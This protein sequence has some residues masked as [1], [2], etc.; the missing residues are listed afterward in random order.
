MFGHENGYIYRYN[1]AR[2]YI[3]EKTLY[4]NE[5]NQT[6]VYCARD[7]KI[8]RTVVLK[9]IAVRTQKEKRIVENEVKNMILA[10]EKTEFTP[11]VY[12]Y[13]WYSENGTYIVIMQ[14]ISG[15]SLREILKEQRESGTENIGYNLDLWKKICAVMAA[16]HEVRGFYHKDLKPENIIIR[17]KNTGIKIYI[18]DFGISGPSGFRNMGTVRYMAPEQRNIRRDLF[19]S[20]STDVFS[21][22][23]IGYELLAGRAPEIG[24]DYT[25]N[26]RSRR[27]EKSPDITEENL[28]LKNAGRVKGIIDRAT[29]MRP[30]ERYRNAGELYAALKNLHL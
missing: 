10:E 9:E 11:T 4:E 5:F 26:S 28:R 14:Y 16:V 30:E 17:R 8:G 27:W 24:I 7:K 1:G 3:I 2:E 13:Y 15:K 29:A 23:L 12:D 21:L 6:V 18:I 25:Y 20:S 22:G 19:L